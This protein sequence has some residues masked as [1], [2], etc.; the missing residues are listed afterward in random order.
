MLLATISFIK[1][2]NFIIWFHVSIIKMNADVHTLFI[3]QIA[4]TL[5]VNSV[6]LL[7]FLPVKNCFTLNSSVSEHFSLKAIYKLPVC[8]YFNSI[9]KNEEKNHLL[10][11]TI[12]HARKYFQIEK[13]I[14]KIAFH[15]KRLKL[16]QSN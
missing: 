16:G 1:Q 4:Q 11:Q 9:E 3:N 6:Q 2:I 5:P 15:L 13:F 14:Q 12:S 8:T 7:S 10:L